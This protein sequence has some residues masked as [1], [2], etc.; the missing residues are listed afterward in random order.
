MRRGD[1][2]VEAGLCRSRDSSQSREVSLT[3][4]FLRPNATTTSRGRG[5]GVLGIP[6][7]Y[8]RRLKRYCPNT[9]DGTSMQASTVWHRCQWKVTVTDIRRHSH[10]FRSVTVTS[11]VRPVQH[12]SESEWPTS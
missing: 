5:A 11:G 9:G 10:D 2:Y 1:R 4:T 8:V 7:D 3:L 12:W 6:V